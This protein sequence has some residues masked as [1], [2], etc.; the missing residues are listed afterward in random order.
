MQPNYKEEIDKKVE[1]MVEIFSI[2][3][4]HDKIQQQ[5]KPILKFIDLFAFLT[6]SFGVEN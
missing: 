2:G 5:N 4:Y 6:N 1:E 3:V